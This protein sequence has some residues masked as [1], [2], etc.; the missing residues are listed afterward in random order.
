MEGEILYRSFKEKRS[1]VHAFLDD[2]AFVIRTYIDLYTVTFDE[3][4]LKRAVYFTNYT[5]EQFFDTKDGFFFYTANVSQALIARKKEL[6][7]NVIPSSN[8]VMAQNLHHLGILSDRQ[9]WKHT[10]ANMVGSLA[11][12]VTGEPNYMSHWGIVLMEVRN[13][14]SEVVVVG[15]GCESTTAQLNATYN[16][17]MLTMGTIEG[18]QLPLLQDK[19]AVNGKTTI[20]VCYNK[21]C[22]LPVHRISDALDQIIP[23]HPAELRH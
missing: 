7:D 1:T 13:G 8:S 18:S 22:R 3:Y 4:Y 5:I 14:M 19:I 12:L 21:T 20:Y 10:A 16:P 23:K 15:E 17:F 2:Y 11:Q 9:D 6:F